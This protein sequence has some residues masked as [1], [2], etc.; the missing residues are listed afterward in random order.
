MIA[1]SSNVS[2][3]CYGLGAVEKFELVKQ[4]AEIRDGPSVAGQVIKR[5]ELL[6]PARCIISVTG[7][8]KGLA[9]G[10]E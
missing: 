2:E 10:G 7:E 5:E 6:R 4:P 3:L 8:V 9:N 1:S